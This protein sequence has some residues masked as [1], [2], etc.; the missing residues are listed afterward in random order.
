MRST[1]I[2]AF[3]TGRR[4]TKIYSFLRA[5]FHLFLFSFSI[6][7]NTVVF[8]KSDFAPAYSP[9]TSGLDYANLRQT[10]QPWSIHIARLD[11]SRKDFQ[12]ITTLGKGTIQGLAPLSAQTK[13]ARSPQLNPIAAVNGD[14]FLIAPGPYQGDPKG[15]QILD[16]E[17]V[18]APESASFWTESTGKLHLENVSSKFL[19]TWPDGAK[20]SFGLNETP[21]TN[22]IVLFTRIFGGSTRNTNG[23]EI[24]L[25]RERG[26]WLPLRANENYRAKVRELRTRGDTPLT[27]HTMVL[28][29]GRALTNKFAKLKVG[30]IFQISTAASQPVN[31]AEFAIAGGPILVTRG[32]EQK[33]PTKGANTYLLPRH[34]RTALGWNNNYFFL[35]EVDGRQKDLS[36]GM[37]FAELAHLMKEIGCTEAMNLDGGGSATFWLNG[38]VMNSPSD[39][40]ERSLANAVIIAHRETTTR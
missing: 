12:I 22:G 16:G 23:L 20:N 4:P 1:S 5:V 30:E 13:A 34:P 18:S 27:G 6:L 14:F 21:K 31:P 17:L 8:A 10:N 39:K 40:R 33:W 29:V 38:K 37:S 35:V 11:R 7:G 24:I 15:L 9:A 25:E 19:L 2:G 32:K 28:S 3:A 26:L 36:I